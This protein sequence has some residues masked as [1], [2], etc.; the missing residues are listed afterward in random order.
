MLC[1]ERK[2]SSKQTDLAQLLNVD[3]VPIK[4]EDL[5]VILG[6][7][8][9]TSRKER[10]SGAIIS[11]YGYYLV[12]DIGELKNLA[13]RIGEAM[14]EV[15]PEIRFLMVAAQFCGKSRFA[16]CLHMERATV[17]DLNRMRFY[18]AMAAATILGLSTY[19][20]MGAGC[21]STQAVS[22]D[23]SKYK[24]LLDI[25]G[26][27]TIDDMTIV[28]ARST[29][30]QVMRVRT[31]WF[32][33]PEGV[34]VEEL[35]TTSKFDSGIRVVSEMVGTV[36]DSLVS[37][38]KR[39][40]RKE[41][42]ITVTDRHFRKVWKRTLE[43]TSSRPCKDS[44]FDFRIY[45]DYMRHEMECLNTNTR[46]VCRRTMTN[47]LIEHSGPDQCHV[48]PREH[49]GAKCKAAEVTLYGLLTEYMVVYIRYK[50]L[51]CGEVGPRGGW[52]TALE[53]IYGT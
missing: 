53:S 33:F 40:T 22:R 18:H 41:Q 12:P 1:L 2:I 6:L 27:S 46:R 26:L 29:C 4:L 23:N 36:V 10:G 11:K 28:D 7:R 49:I 30:I 35:K 19:E 17:Y 16:S 38:A 8:I 15:T 44:N 9:C 31:Q 52:V 47:P 42:S 34:E 25:C 24:Q 45:S 20:T 14:N 21:C 5:V 37:L 13:Y 39:S 51:L 50:C 32:I 48:R 3:N 43:L